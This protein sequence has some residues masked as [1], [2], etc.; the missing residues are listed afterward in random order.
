MSK[1]LTAFRNSPTG[2]LIAKQEKGRATLR[3]TLQQ[4]NQLNLNHVAGGALGGAGFN[5]H[6]RRR[7]SVG[8]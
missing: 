4:A 5:H 7:V 1:A 2:T 8:D 3:N 6:G